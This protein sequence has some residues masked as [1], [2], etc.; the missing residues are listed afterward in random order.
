MRHR[1]NRR[2]AQPINAGS[3]AD[4]A[5]LLLIFFLVTTTIVVDSGIQVQLPPWAD[6]PPQD[7][8]DRNVLSIKIN[9]SNALAVEDREIR[10]SQLRAQVKDFILN[11]NALPTQPSS[12][13]K[14]VV[15]LLHDR[16]TQ[17]ATYLEV[18]NEVVAAYHELWEA[19]ARNQHH[20]SYAQL[21]PRQQRDI[22]QRIP[23]VISE[24]E[25]VDLAGKQ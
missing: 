15:S 13:N 7:I 22:R 10:P 5:F 12:P 19:Q 6:V 25:P 1:T 4:I 8:P 14:A 2:P 11:P 24:A 18:Y 23:L 20:I 21:S 17:Y 3:M 9:A 16:G